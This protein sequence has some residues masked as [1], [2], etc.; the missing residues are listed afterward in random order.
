VTKV[1]V[2]IS[3][4]VQGSG[5]VVC[6]TMDGNTPTLDSEAYTESFEITTF[7]TTVIKAFMTSEGQAESKLTTRH[8]HVLERVATPT[9]DVTS[10]TFVDTITVHLA[11]LTEGARIRYTVNGQTPTA[12]SEECVDGK[13][14]TLGLSLGHEASYIVKA[15]AILAL[16]MGTSFELKS[17]RIVVQSQTQKPMIQPPDSAG[18]FKDKVMV[19][20]SCATP[21]SNILYTVDGSSPLTS[22]SK[23]YYDGPFQMKG[24]YPLNNTVVALALASHSS[25]S[26][27][28]TSHF[29]I[30]RQ[31]CIP[32]F[33]RKR[34][35]F[36][37]GVPITITCSGEYGEKAGVVMYYV[38]SREGIS[39]EDVSDSTD[40]SSFNATNPGSILYTGPIHLTEQGNYT[41]AAVAMGQDFISS[42]AIVSPL[43]VVEAEPTC[44]E[45]EY[46]PGTASNRY[47]RVFCL[48]VSVNERLHLTLQRA[49]RFLPHIISPH[50]STSTHTHPT[51]PFCFAIE[52]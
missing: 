2:S 14:I 28:A 15:I 37:A 18:P 8:F 45:N 34:G 51:T 10:G 6:M 12:A 16:G 25:M 33:S 31:A 7:G 1:V 46:Q 47:R 38:I 43:F 30:K 17:G 39:S 26:L 19:I 9:I 5:L 41:I 40:A 22:H 4:Y 24:L 44:E 50:I 27:E 13:G 11:T 48:S 52:T 32:L 35:T 21:H 42:A 3:N 20:V 23:M 29:V 49:N 36:I